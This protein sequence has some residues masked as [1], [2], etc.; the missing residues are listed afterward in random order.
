MGFWWFM[1]LCDLLIPLMMILFGRMMWKHPP[2]SI[3]A[4]VGYR[5][6]RSMKNMDTWKFAHDYCGRLWWRTG[7]LM[8][9]LSAAVHVPVYGKSENVI[10]TVGGVLCTIQCVALIL[11]IFP[12]E[13]ALKRNFPE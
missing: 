4:V 5:T 12:T 3:N 8:L 1:F 9:L 10:G 13:R 7:W 11:S 6:K 2:K